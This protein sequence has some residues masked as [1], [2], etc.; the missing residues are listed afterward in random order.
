MT[1]FQNVMKNQQKS[2]YHNFQN[3]ELCKLKNFI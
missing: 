3:W 2:K 1:N